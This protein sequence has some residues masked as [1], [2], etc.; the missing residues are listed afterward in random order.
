[1]KIYMFVYNNCKHDSRVLKEAKTLADAGYDV[2]VIAVLDKITEPYEER[3]GFKIIRVIKDPI[4]YKI[5]RARKSFRLIA[6]IKNSLRMIAR[7]GLFPARKF[8]NLLFFPF[9]RLKYR[10]PGDQSSVS[11]HYG[12]MSRLRQAFGEIDQ[13]VKEKG[14]RGY[15]REVT[16][17][18]PAYF[19]SVGW[20]LFLSYYGY[21]CL[22]KALY[23]GIRRP[24][25]IIKAIFY[26]RLRDFLMVFH[27]PLSF[28][29]YYYRSL[30]LVKQEPADIYHAHDLNT[31]PVAYW[32]SRKHHAKLVY[33]SHELYVERNTLRPPSFL[34][35][36]LLSRVEM[37]LIRR[38]DSVITVNE[39]IAKELARRYSVP[40]PSVIMNTPSQNVRSS[41]DKRKFLR[42]FLGIR[43]DHRILLYSGAITF[44][45][46]LEKV[47]ESLLYLPNCHLVLMGYGTEEY[48]GHLQ[49]LALEKGVESRLSFFGPVPSE[50]VTMYA[51][52]ADLGIAAIE[53]VCLSYYYCSPNKVFEYIHAGLPVAA[54]AFPELERVIEEHGTGVTF[55]PDDPQDIA[56]AIRS[57]LENVEL[58]MHMRANAREA[59]KVYNWQQEEKKLVKIYKG[60]Q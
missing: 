35:K 18:Y 11:K 28:L 29:D 38:S 14:F 25:T 55:D 58:Q 36:F 5:L 23:W 49:I 24:A 53:N 33:D 48:K 60:L 22:K 57:I 40:T 9:A 34:E 6:L 41:E 59:A 50:E 56:R 21:R 15:V 12:L 45:R 1:M 2:I 4:H 10:S 42:E 44:N 51:A 31:L 47:I 16:E 37:F 30:R 26:A 39:T 27:K 54:S 19:L 46:G 13:G 43:D 8:R 20:T 17:T 7:V 52:G 3:D 32:A